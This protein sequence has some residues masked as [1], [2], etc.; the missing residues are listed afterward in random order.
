MKSNIALYSFMLMIAGCNLDLPGGGSNCTEV[1][2]FGLTVYLTDQNGDP[3]T[4]ATVVITE[5]QDEETL[6]VVQD[7][8]YTGAGERQ[9]TYTLTIEA[10]GF[11]PVTI[12]NIVI[13]GDECHVTPVGRDVTLQPAQ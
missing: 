8:F 7:G 6:V 1:F 9:G 5:G 4:G 2:I 11:E 12:N 10:T 3:V 13:T